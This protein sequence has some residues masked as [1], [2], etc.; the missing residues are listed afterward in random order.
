LQFCFYF[1]LAKWQLKIKEEKF[2]KKLMEKFEEL[3]KTLHKSSDVLFE[4]KK[5][6]IGEQFGQLEEILTNRIL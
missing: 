3:E 2:E 1:A 4:A 5:K 6:A